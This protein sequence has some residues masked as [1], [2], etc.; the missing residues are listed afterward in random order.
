MIQLQVLNKILRDKDASIITLNNLAENNAAST[1]ETSAMA[2]DLKT[3]VEE[4]S[5]VI[6]SL[7][8]DMI[9]LSQSMKKFK[10]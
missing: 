4:S 7:S 3:A 1:Q 2:T 8:N 5:D 10:L 6:K 9:N